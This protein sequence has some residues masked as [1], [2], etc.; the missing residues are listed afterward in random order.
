M[1]LKMN[2]IKKIQRK[3]KEQGLIKFICFCVTTLLYIIVKSIFLSMLKLTKV[4]DKTILFSSEPDFSDNSKA[5]YEY[6][7]NC[8]KYK[9]YKYIWLISK[10]KN[11]KKYNYANTK[12][13]KSESSMHN[14]KTLKSL[15][16]ISKSKVLYFTH[17][18]PVNCNK[19]KKNQLVINLWHGCGYKN[20]QSSNTSFIERQ[21]FDYALVPGKI[22]VNTKTKFWGCDKKQVMTIGYPRFD[23]LIKE[24]KTTEE[25]VNCLKKDNKLILWMP[26]FRNTGKGYYPEEQ[27]EKMFDLPLLNSEKELI[28]LNKICKKHKVLLCIKRHPR[29]L[30]YSCEKEKFSN[31][32]FINNDTLIKENIDLYSLLKY[33]DGLITDYSSVA[34]DYILLDKPIGFT[35]DDFEKY[36]K[37]RGFVFEN[38]KDYMPGHHIYNFDD[39]RQYIEDIGNNNDWYKEN[40]HSIMNEVHNPCKN[41]C[42]RIVKKIEKLKEEI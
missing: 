39:M 30:K 34:I 29:Q 13:I 16:Y 33:T 17:S 26:T 10:N 42:E 18:S 28:E 7:I 4:D 38:P 15:Y 25:F 35:L 5:L 8:D 1:G 6:Y 24:N 40:R 14:G 9:D 37:T 20:I 31:I 21:P 41:Y 11:T 22:F 32:I 2:I 27:I 36:S 19:K 23:L 3:I 12:F